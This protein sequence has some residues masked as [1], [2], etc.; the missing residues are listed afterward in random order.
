MWTMVV[1]LMENLPLFRGP[2]HGALATTAE[3]RVAHVGITG[4]SSFVLIVA[5][6]YIYIYI[7]MQLEQLERMRSE[8]IRDAD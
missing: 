2:K 6:I 4:Q 1:T 8:I 3:P 5:Y 7:Y